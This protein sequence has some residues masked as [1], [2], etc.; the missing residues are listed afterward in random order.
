MSKSR[1][2]AIPKPDERG[3]LAGALSREKGLTLRLRDSAERTKLEERIKDPKTSTRELEDLQ[4]GIWRYVLYFDLATSNA[5]IDQNRPFDGFTK[6]AFGAGL[7]ALFASYWAHMLLPI[8]IKDP[9][10][11]HEYNKM[12]RQEREELRTELARIHTMVT[13]MLL[14][15]GRDKDNSCNELETPPERPKKSY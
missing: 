1:E 10:K 13:K 15:R 14:D 8:G 4:R 11:R 2:L 12:V 9:Y 7:L 5:D 3:H 6:E